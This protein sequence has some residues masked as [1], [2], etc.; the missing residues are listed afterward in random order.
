MLRGPVQ[1][2]VSGR[3]P[4]HRLLSLAPLPPHLL[5]RV[6]QDAPLPLEEDA[7]GRDAEEYHGQPGPRDHCS[8]LHQ[9]PAKIWEISFLLRLL[10]VPQPRDGCPLHV[11]HRRP[12][13]Q[14]VLRLWTGGVPLR[15]GREVHQP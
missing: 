5:L 15:L 14:Q 8:Q 3:R 1:D 10:R 11:R 2:R 7:R 13:T 9:V 6:R 12:P 4:G